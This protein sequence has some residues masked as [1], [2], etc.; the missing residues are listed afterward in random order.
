MKQRP[1]MELLLKLEAGGVSDVG[2]RLQEWQAIEDPDGRERR[3]KNRWAGIG[4]IDDGGYIKSSGPDVWGSRTVLVE[5]DHA[6]RCVEYDISHSRGR[7]HDTALHENIP[8]KR[9]CGQCAR[10]KGCL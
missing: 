5:T 3:G 9:H 2:S 10:L 7:G 1:I 6:S 8:A 4:E